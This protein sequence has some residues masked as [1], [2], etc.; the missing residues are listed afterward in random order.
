MECATLSIH[1]ATP[2]ASHGT[3]ETPV[4]RFYLS[5]SPRG[6]RG[7]GAATAGRDT[8]GDAG[9][10]G[11]LASLQQDV[12]RGGGHDAGPPGAARPHTLCVALRV[13]GVRESSGPGWGAPDVQPPGA[14]AW[15]HRLWSGQAGAIIHWGCLGREGTA[16]ERPGTYRDGV[17]GGKKY[18]VM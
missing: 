1:L 2:P 7:A 17:W 4:P 18:G 12:C 8:H 6:C 13:R 5:P 16:S 14:Q 9:E 10:A 11:V 3:H 15:G